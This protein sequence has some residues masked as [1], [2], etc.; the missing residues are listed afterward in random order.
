MDMIREERWVPVT[1]S[2]DRWAPRSKES[3]QAALRDYP[4]G[5]AFSDGAVWDGVER[6]V[7]EVR[8]VSPWVAVIE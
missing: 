4:V 5:G 3:A 2:G 8:Y 6:I 7:Y 1:E